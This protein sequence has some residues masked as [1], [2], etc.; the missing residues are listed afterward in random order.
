[1][2]SGFPPKVKENLGYGLHLLQIGEMPS[3]SRPMPGLNT[4]VF[5]LRDQDER[6]WYR[7]IY[8]RIGESIYVLHCFEKQSNKTEQRDVDTARARLRN[9]EERIREER[10]R[11]R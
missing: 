11:A 9:V 10:R 7:V 1:V 6:A 2:I 4:G 8:K 3:D 5:E